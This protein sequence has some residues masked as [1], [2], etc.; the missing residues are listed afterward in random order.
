MSFDMSDSAINNQ[1]YK[2]IRWALKLTNSD[3]VSIMNDAGIEISK[4]KADSW[5][6]GE[7]SL[8]GGTG[9]SPA[10]KLARF[11][12]MTDDEFRSFCVG[13]SSY[14]RDSEDD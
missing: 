8:K 6:R 12:V 13:L 11:R 14:Q 5:N 7:N 9:N 10:K 3:V 2:R 1:C 4:S